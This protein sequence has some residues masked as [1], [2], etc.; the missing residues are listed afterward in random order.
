[1][2][3][4][5]AKGPEPMKMRIRPCCPDRGTEFQFSLSG[6]EKRQAELASNPMSVTW[7]L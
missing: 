2:G 4:M 1:M 5:K 3:P 6:N 7:W